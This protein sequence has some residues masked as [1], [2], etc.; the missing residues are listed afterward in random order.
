MPSTNSFRHISLADTAISGQTI[1]PLENHLRD[2]GVNDA[3][4]FGRR[5]ASYLWRGCA[6][7]Q[8]DCMTAIP[9]KGNKPWKT[10]TDQTMSRKNANATI[11]FS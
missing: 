2:Q 11:Q 3:T 9:F 1:R 7:R 4:C 8:E 6:R 10:A 5:V